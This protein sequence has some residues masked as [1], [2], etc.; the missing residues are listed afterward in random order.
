M[1][2]RLTS[3]PRVGSGAISLEVTSWTKPAQLDK[4]RSNRSFGKPPGG[5]PLLR[6]RYH[7][8]GTSPEGMELCQTELLQGSSKGTNVPSGTFHLFQCM[9]E[10]VHKGVLP[11]IQLHKFPPTT[12]EKLINSLLEVTT[13]TREGGK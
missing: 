10:G 2:I 4:L 3:L 1:A 6:R 12:T 9:G 5:G 13:S 8:E 11:R 7:Q